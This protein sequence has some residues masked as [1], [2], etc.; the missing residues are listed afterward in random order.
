[1]SKKTEIQVLRGEISVTGERIR[2]LCI[3]LFSVILCIAQSLPTHAAD[4]TGS[5][6]KAVV[7]LLDASGSMKTND[8]N[9][10]ARDGITQLVYTLPTN[11]EVGFVAYHTEVTAIQSLVENDQREQVIKVAEEV[12][13][14]GYSNAGAGLAAAVE[15][16]EEATAKEKHIVLLSD[17]EVLLA[18][19]EGTNLSKES[20]QKATQ[21]AKEEGICIHVIGLGEEM[22]DRDNAI[23]QAAA[24]TGGGS[25]Y[26]PQAL[27][28]QSAIDAILTEKLGI[29]QITAAIVESSG[30]EEKVV[31]D[32]PFS[33]AH[34]VRVLLTGSSAIEHLQTSFRAEQA[35][36]RN[37]ERYALIELQNPQSEQMELFFQGKE[38]N[39]VRITLIAEYR[40]GARAEIRYQDSELAEDE[41]EYYQRE[42][43]ITYTFFDEE[44]REIQLWTE[45]Y[46]Q[47]G[48]IILKEGEEEKE[49][50]LD[51]GQL[52][53]QMAVTEAVLIHTSFD[54]SLLPVNVLS[55]TPIQV[56]LEAPP[57]LPAKQPPYVL[58]AILGFTCLGILAVLLYR[59]RSKPE[60]IP[61]KENRPAPGK[62]SYVGNLRLYILRAPSGQ[63]IEPLAYDLFRLSSDKVL[64]FAEMLESCGIKEVF[65][66]AERIYISSGQGKSIIL[67]NQSDC[68]ILKSGEILMKNKSYQLFEDAKVDITF[69]DEV[70]ELT[71]QYK[72]LK[73]GQ[74]R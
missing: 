47:Q 27:E 5:N 46:F 72:V 7:F 10:Y 22:G 28:I 11:Y 37:G 60:V 14:K 56:E 45:D 18:D 2:T 49:V 21:R 32:L 53:S 31:I 43:A 41:A 38:G 20:Y 70:S 71:V 12:E 64:S 58:Y 13:Y 50:M 73:P 15:L 51:K 63:D 66:G 24:H 9:G 17:G 16:L 29:K 65:P 3:L 52:T 44:N 39:Q 42:A 40:V 8:P 69:E 36:Q 68:C 6:T 34:K 23:F 35:S 48:R 61:E 74:M 30:S 59:G 57:S 26:T 1:M 62:A 4:K 54:C 55:L 67:T 33:H 25:W 19:E